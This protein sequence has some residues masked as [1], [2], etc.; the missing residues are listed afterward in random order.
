L[1]ILQNLGIALSLP[2]PHAV[3]ENA[4][5]HYR[6]CCIHVRGQPCWFMDSLWTIGAFLAKIWRLEA[7]EME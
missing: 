3:V 7:L 5:L 1:C 6:C 2:L 4:W